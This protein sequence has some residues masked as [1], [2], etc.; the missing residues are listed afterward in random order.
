MPNIDDL[1]RMTGQDNDL[2]GEGNAGK[3]VENKNDKALASQFGG[4]ADCSRKAI[5]HTPSSA[6]RNRSK[7][8]R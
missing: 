8:A 3:V 4:G 1:A 7:Q 2:S 5:P 6:T